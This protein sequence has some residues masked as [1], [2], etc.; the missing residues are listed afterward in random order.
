MDKEVASVA[1]TQVVLSLLTTTK[2]K[3]PILGVS[4][5]RLARRV[6][7]VHRQTTVGTSGQIRFC[8]VACWWI[9]A[10]PTA[11]R[12]PRSLVCGSENVCL[13]LA[14]AVCHNVVNLDNLRSHSLVDLFA[15]KTPE[16]ELRIELNTVERANTHGVAQFTHIRHRT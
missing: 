6:V 8:D 13:A 4:S 5:R 11:L 9:C 15:A 1:V 12:S 7:A 14:G 2:S 10:A 16:D 3:T